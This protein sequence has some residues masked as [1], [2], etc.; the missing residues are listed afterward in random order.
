MAGK[1]LSLKELRVLFRTDIQQWL[2]HTSPLA[3][4]MYEQSMAVKRLKEVQKM[5]A[6]ELC[7][8]RTRKSAALKSSQGRVPR[9]RFG[10]GKCP[11]VEANGFDC[12]SR[13]CGSDGKYSMMHV[14]VSVSCHYQHVL[15]IPCLFIK[16]S[17]RVV[18][19]V[20]FWRWQVSWRKSK[21][22]RLRDESQWIGR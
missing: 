17:I 3:K 7:S 6:R 18:P 14:S 9:V 20:S 22:I 16:P 5:P 11:G 2:K 4:A 19:V 12:G 8:R 13:V 15:I 10:G 1:V 21:R